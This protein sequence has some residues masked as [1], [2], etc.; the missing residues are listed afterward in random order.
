MFAQA[1]YGLDIARNGCFRKF[2][3][4]KAQLG[5]AV[6]EAVLELA[7]LKFELAGAIDTGL[8]TAEHAAELLQLAGSELGPALEFGKKPLDQQRG[9][10]PGKVAAILGD[11]A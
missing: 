9:G 5:F 7:Q 8:E 1:T 4:R 11:L 2:I 3:T 6:G 10:G